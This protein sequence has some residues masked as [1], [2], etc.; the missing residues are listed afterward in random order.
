M[1]TYDYACEACGRKFDRFQGIHEPPIERCP[2][3]GGPV[4]RLI[5]SGGPLFVKGSGGG[6]CSL[7]ETGKT[8]CGRD[9]RCGESSCGGHRT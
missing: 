1:P 6:S 5:S 4:R 3:C 7:E 8:C 2:A 9:A